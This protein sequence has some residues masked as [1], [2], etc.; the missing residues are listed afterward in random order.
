LPDDALLIGL[1][2]RFN[3]VK[4]H[5]TFLQAAGLLARQIPA[6]HFV[7]IGPDVTD[8]NE[9]LR[10]W[11][12]ESGIAEQVHLLGERPDIPRVTAALDIATCASYGESFPIV[13]G[14][15][16]AC[17]VPCVVT[18]VGDAA[19]MVADTGHVVPPRDAR[20]LATAWREL[21]ELGAAERQAL[22]ARARVRI[23]ENYS[24]H[25][26]VRQYEELCA[27]VATSRSDAVAHPS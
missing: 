6:P 16:M 12:Q 2:A 8:C 23:E 11:V 4:G 7:L 24:L 22:G 25:S 27:R 5:Q 1:V 19:S 17:G 3:P 26:T 14:E 15:A 18:D 13:V 10:G 9:L 20:A 21:L